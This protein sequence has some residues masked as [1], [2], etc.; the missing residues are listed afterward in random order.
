MLEVK[1]EL[2]ESIVEILCYMKLMLQVDIV[3]HILQVFM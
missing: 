2:L 3:I 1:V